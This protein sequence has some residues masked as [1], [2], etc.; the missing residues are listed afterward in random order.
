M[1]HDDHTFKN[2]RNP[3]D[4]LSGDIKDYFQLVKETLDR[5]DPSVI[6]RFT[7]LLLDCNKKGNTIFVFG[8]GGS[9]ANASHFCGD[10][11][12]GLSY[13]SLKR[14]KAVCLND[15]IPA[16]MAVANDISYDDIFVEQLKNFVT[17]GDVVIGLSGSGNSENVVRALSYGKTAGASTVAMCGF[18]GGKIH[19]MA[20]LSIHADIMDMEVSEDIHLIVAHCVKRMLMNKLNIPCPYD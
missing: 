10:F 8:N 16:L 11:I 3:S 13:G 6:E 7:E 5:I 14:F 20:D 15:N 18:D 4:H 1:Q 12:K 9:G 2:D 19:K 17:E